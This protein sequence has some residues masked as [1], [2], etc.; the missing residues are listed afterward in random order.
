M[1]NHQDYVELK[2][3]TEGTTDT[4]TTGTGGGRKR[5][6]T[7]AN[8][9]GPINKSISAPSSPQQ[10]RQ[11]GLSFAVPVCDVLLVRLH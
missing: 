6:M 1:H 8:L 2:E 3:K 11:R 7:V 5:S 4:A 10:T 9:L